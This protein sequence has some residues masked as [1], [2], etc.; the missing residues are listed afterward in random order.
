MAWFITIPAS[1]MLIGRRHM[2]WQCG[3]RWRGG[4]L[5]FE[6]IAFQKRCAPFDIVSYLSSPKRAERI[7]LRRR[8]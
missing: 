2:K 8:T 1:L 5:L 4:R 6:M 7:S 3:Q